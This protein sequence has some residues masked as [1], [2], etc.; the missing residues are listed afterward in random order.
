[1]TPKFTKT[2]ARALRMTL[3]TPSRSATEASPPLIDSPLHSYRS[4]RRVASVA[5]VVLAAYWYWSPWIVLATL[6]DAARRADVSV[7]EQH[8]DH[9]RL[10][11][12]LQRRCSNEATTAASS[13]PPRNGPVDVPGD[14]IGSPRCPLS[15][16]AMPDGQRIMQFMT[17]GR[18]DA[19]PAGLETIDLHSASAAPRSPVRLSL[20]HVSTDRFVVHVPRPD[21]ATPVAVSA[22]VPCLVFER[23]GFATWR[24]TDIAAARPR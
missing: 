16:G 2:A 23:L 17:S 21:S 10:R 1:M 6:S 20:E 14:F 8:I 18:L 11:S 22:P 15:L 7:F 5:L 9:G 13:L 4:T 3:A 19:A 12:N 24:M